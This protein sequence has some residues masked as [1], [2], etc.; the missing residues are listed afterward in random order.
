[1]AEVSL[2]TENGDHEI[3]NYEQFANVISST[4]Q[5]NNYDHRFT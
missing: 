2:F 5:Q 3:F 1:M 4:Q